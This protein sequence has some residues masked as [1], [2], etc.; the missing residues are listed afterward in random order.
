[1]V[2]R[3]LQGVAQGVPTLHLAKE[4]GLDRKHLL[5]RRHKIQE[6]AANACS[7]DPLLDEIVE[8]DEL[9]QNAGEKGKLHPDPSDPPRY[10]ANK[11][12]GHGTWKNDRPPILGIVGW[13]SDQIRLEVK[14]QRTTG[15]RAHR[16]VRHPAG[17][18]GQHG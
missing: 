7:R 11:V 8:A 4:L 18:S 13:E 2:V 12:R 15:P 14:K 6:S 3:I 5:E 10:R 16:C 17:S 1:M 9:Y